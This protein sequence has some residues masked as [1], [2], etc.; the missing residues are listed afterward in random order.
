VTPDSMRDETGRLW[1]AVC[2]EPARATLA[3]A[4]LQAAGLDAWWPHYMA[5]ITRRI[6]TR[7]RK[8]T[9]LRGLFSGYMFAGLDEPGQ[10]SL[11]AGP[12]NC[13]RI[14]GCD[15]V[16]RDGCA[17]AFVR[18][19]ELADW[20]KKALNDEG[21]FDPPSWANARHGPSYMPRQG[22]HVRLTA[23]SFAGFI[24]AVTRV[25]GSRVDGEV[26]QEWFNIRPKF[27]VDLCQIEPA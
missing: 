22:D 9:V 23:G 2:Y 21:L 17:P 20:R 3:R 16:V 1:V 13:G 15:D 19:D 14:R 6:G 5:T 12:D 27:S 18:P 11:I 10:V 8:A 7:D 4:G 25:V 24:A 26:I